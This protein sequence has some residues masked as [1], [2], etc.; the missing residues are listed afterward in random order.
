MTEDEKK[1]LATIDAL[2]KKMQEA[3]K[4]DTR[5]A[6]LNFNERD[7]ANQPNNEEANQLWEKLAKHTED[8]ISRGMQGFDTWMAAMSQILNHCLML[9]KAINASYPPSVS[10][11]K[12]VNWVQLNREIAALEK[13]KTQLPNT[14]QLEAR[15][16]K[17]EELHEILE[18]IKTK[19]AKKG[20][21]LDAS[22]PA[23]E[24]EPEEPAVA[25]RPPR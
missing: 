13:I 7:A 11:M 21:T 8:L 23:P 24:L 2:T 16:A 12:I 14:E 10:T 22:E 15:N 20:I 18:D 4:F 3:Y 1:V 5:Q 9:A 25:P 17:I 6:R 19:A